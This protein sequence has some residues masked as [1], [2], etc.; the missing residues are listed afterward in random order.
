MSTKSR[1]LSM[2]VIGAGRIGML[3]AHN[4]AR[5]V[6]HAQVVMVADPRIACAR[7]AATVARAHAAVADYR[8]ILA[9]PDVD[10]VVISAS[11]D[12]HAR[13]IGEAAAAGKHIFCEKP[14]DHDLDR[15]RTALQAVAKAGVRFQVGFNRRFDPDFQAMARQVRS[16]SIG[17]PQLL[18]ITSR[19]PE[20]P[21]ADYIRV[22]GGLFL[23]MS[24]HDLDMARFLMQEPVVEVFAAGSAFDPAILALGDIDTAV[25]VLRFASGALCCIDNSR[26]AVYG[27]D[28]RLEVFGTHGCLTVPNRTPTQVEHWDASGQHRDRPQHFFLER[29]QE[30]YVLEL[31]E[32][33][34][35]VRQGREIS[36]SGHDG[37]QAIV[38]AQAARASLLQGKPVQID[39]ATMPLD[40]A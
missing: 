1:E 33:V 8:E 6:P 23:D 9:A 31:Q 5:R 26:R 35:C 39:A 7:A 27:Y 30:S 29:Y 12:T 32:F 25:I 11:T 37:L 40:A 38:L 34:D 4:L 28:Q 13:I 22:S 18:R 24:I 17:T 36:V 16:G 15:I 20:P 19:D 2:G 3:H 21:P 10:A 14:I